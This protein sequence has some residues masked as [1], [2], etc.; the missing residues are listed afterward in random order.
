[1]IATAT[2]KEDLMIQMTLRNT[3]YRIRYGGLIRNIQNSIERETRVPVKT[4]N[5]MR[6]PNTKEI[7]KMRD[8]ELSPA[9]NVKCKAIT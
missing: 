1:M 9:S 5:T 3:K 6:D 4:T 7:S 8:L 2:S